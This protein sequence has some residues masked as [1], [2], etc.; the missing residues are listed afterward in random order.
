MLTTAGPG[1][2]AANIAPNCTAHRYLPVIA[3]V[4][5]V[6]DVSDRSL[7]PFC[8]CLATASEVI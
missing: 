6:S 2:L 3:L 8:N 1:S 4:S 7:D 5:D